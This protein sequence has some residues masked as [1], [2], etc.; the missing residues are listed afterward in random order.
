MKTNLAA[1]EKSLYSLMLKNIKE[2]D[3]TPMLFMITKDGVEYDNI[4][5]FELPPDVE[6]YREKA[7]EFSTTWVNKD[8]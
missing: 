8:K 7:Y 5:K 2:E 6:P 3:S 4:D 1:E